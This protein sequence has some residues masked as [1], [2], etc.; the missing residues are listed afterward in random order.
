MDPMFIETPYI[1]MYIETP[2]ISAVR[3]ALCLLR[4]PVD[5]QNVDNG[6]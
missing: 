2:Y 3:W 6:K 5:K 1:T 4:H